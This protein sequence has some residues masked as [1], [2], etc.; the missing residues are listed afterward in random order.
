MVFS[1]LATSQKRRRRVQEDFFTRFAA[2]RLR[3]NLLVPHLSAFAASLR[4]D[5]YAA[6]TLQSKVALLADLSQWLAR[7][8]V[9]V[10]ELDERRADAFI[11]CRERKGGVR[12]GERET[13]RQFLAHMR[14]RGVV[15]S[16]VPPCDTSPL[17]AILNR[18]E[19]HLRS[20]RGLVTAT[21]V[22]YIPFARRFLVERFQQ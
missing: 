20:E 13:L 15:P 6:V 2:E 18:Y 8:N 5:G 1:E 9:S 3:G 12:R 4:E 10:T 17:A 19:R 14:N 11:R 21:V 22:N 7:K 16:P